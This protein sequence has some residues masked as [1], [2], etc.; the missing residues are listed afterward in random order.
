MLE[1]LLAV[2]KND[3]NL[4]NKL[5]KNKINVNEST[6]L[7]NTALMVAAYKG[8][9]AIVES[10]VKAGAEINLQN[11][12]G[13]SALMLATVENNVDIVKFLL[14]NGASKDL[15]SKYDKTTALKLAKLYEYTKIISLL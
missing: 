4:V 6:A 5:I 12:D 11:F 8:N 13:Y 10:L 7:G 2:E 9:S 14:Q 15:E 3:L 1:M